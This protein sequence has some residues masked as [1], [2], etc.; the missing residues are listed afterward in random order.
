MP[1]RAAVALSTSHLSS[2]C[3]MKISANANEDSSCYE[4]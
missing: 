2:E 1:R 4:E 3:H